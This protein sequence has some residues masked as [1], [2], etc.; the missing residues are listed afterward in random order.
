MKY[1]KVHFEFDVP[2]VDLHYI[3]VK[4]AENAEEAERRG[5]EIF[6]RENQ[7]NYSECYVAEV[8]EWEY[9]DEWDVV[10]VEPVFYVENSTLVVEAGDKEEA[11]KRAKEELKFFSHDFVVEEDL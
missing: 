2:D 6:E 11:E 3:Q 1:Y 8:T 4:F 7:A 9:A 5:W 10:V